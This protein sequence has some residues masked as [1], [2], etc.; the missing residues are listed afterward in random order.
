MKES[1]SLIFFFSIQRSGEN[2]FTSPAILQACADASNRVMGAIPVSPATS[3]FQVLS[4]SGAQ[5]RRAPTPVMTPLRMAIAL[6]RPPV[7]EPGPTPLRGGNY[8][9]RRGLSLLRCPRHGVVEP[10]RPSASTA[11]V[12]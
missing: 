6:R 4:V 11:G 2:P 9:E 3:A 5:G 8:H 10:A 7:S 12:F 1:P